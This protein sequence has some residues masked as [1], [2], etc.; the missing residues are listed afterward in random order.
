MIKRKAVFR[1]DCKHNTCFTSGGDG[2]DGNGGRDVLKGAFNVDSPSQ[3]TEYA[4]K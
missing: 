1:E 3:N 2:N 4:F